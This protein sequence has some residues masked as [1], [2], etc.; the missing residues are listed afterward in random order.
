MN[1]ARPILDFAVRLTKVGRF[2]IDL[3]LDDAA[4]AL[5]PECTNG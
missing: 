4:S 2:A 1:P 3:E 5:A